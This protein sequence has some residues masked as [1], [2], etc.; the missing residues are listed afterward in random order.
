LNTLQD[1]LDA[2]GL[3]V[4]VHILGVNDIGQESGNTSMTAGRD[5]PWLQDVPAA[6]VW[7]SWN[8][9]FRDVVILDEKN[10]PI[11]VYNLTV[12]DLGDPKNY[13]ELKALL[14]AATKD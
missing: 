2:L 10:F 1:D 11:A 12:H 5:L 3:P 7:Q 4:A 13:A 8:V 6:S 9:T 14:V